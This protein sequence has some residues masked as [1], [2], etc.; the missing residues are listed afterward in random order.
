MTIAEVHQANTEALRKIEECR[1][2]GKKGTKLDLSDL[3][4][5]TLPP[6]IGQLTALT[7][8]VL[9]GNQLTTLPPELGQLTAL[10]ELF[11]A[12]NPLQEPPLEVAKQGVATI[13]RYF[14]DRA[15]SGTELL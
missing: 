4:L 8:L 12:G 2:L 7:E 9:W 5:T 3:R 14:A 6:A 1:R 10:R 11:L 13:R 15:K